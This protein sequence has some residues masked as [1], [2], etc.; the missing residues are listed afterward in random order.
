MD[1]TKRHNSKMNPQNNFPPSAKAK[2]TNDI[3]EAHEQAPQEKQNIS[4]IARLLRRI[5]NT[6]CT[7][8]IMAAGTA[9][10]AIATCFYTL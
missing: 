7:D 3:C 6:S 5:K 4:K 9:V 1:K 2:N 10:I 8:R